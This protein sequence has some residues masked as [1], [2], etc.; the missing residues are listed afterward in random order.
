MRRVR[1]FAPPAAEANQ[2]AISSQKMTEQETSSAR[3]RSKASSSTALVHV[4]T[5]GYRSSIHVSI[6][7][8]FYPA[9]LCQFTCS[10]FRLSYHVH[11]NGIGS[12]DRCPQNCL[13]YHWNGSRMRSTRMVACC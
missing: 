13:I 11:S 8:S 3:H 10:G 4:I 2:S 6:L 9:Y 1:T 7:P 5:P 12:L